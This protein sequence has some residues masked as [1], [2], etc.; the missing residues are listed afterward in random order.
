MRLYAL[1]QSDRWLRELAEE[2]Q[3]LKQ[4]YRETE[5]GAFFEK[6]LK[7]L[8]DTEQYYKRIYPFQTMFYEFLDRGNQPEYAAAVE[9]FKRLGERN[10]ESEKSSKKPRVTGT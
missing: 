1:S 8:I 6:F 9:L 10:K 2:H 3:S 5:T 7:L 4:E